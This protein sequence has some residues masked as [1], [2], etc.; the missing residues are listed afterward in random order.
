[1]SDEP[2]FAHLPN[3]V[4]VNADPTVEALA[5]VAY[6]GEDLREAYAHGRDLLDQASSL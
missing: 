2:L 4:A 1:M 3:T 6:R 5:R